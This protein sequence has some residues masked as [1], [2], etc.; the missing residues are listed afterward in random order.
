MRKFSNFLLALLLSPVLLAQHV[1]PI[2]DCSQPGFSVLT[3][4][5]NR[6]PREWTAMPSRVVCQLPSFKMDESF[7]AKNVY[8]SRTDKQVLATGFFRVEKINDRWWIVDPQGYLQINVGVCAINKNSSTRNKAAFAAKYN[9][10]TTDWMRATKDSLKHYG[11]YTS[12]AW[13][14]HDN[15]N[16]DKE[17]NPMPYTPIFNF[18]ATY[19]SRRRSSDYS[20]YGYGNPAY[21]NI[22]N[23]SIHVFDPEFEAFCDHFAKTN[24]RPLELDRDVLGFFSDNELTFS[25]HTLVKYLQVTDKSYPGYLAAKQFV[26][27][28]CFTEADVIANRTTSGATTTLAQLKE[29]W[30]YLLTSTYYGTIRQAIKRYA[31]NHMYIGSRLHIP[32][33]DNAGILKAA[34]DNLDIISFNTYNV[35]HT[36]KQK[37]AFWAT[38]GDTPFLVTEFYAKGEDVFM[39][40]GEKYPN[41]SGVGYIVHTQRERG[42]Y[43]Q[44]FCLGLLEAKNCVGW[45][46]FK[47]MDN[48]PEDPGTSDPSNI[49]SNKGLVDNEYNYYTDMM[50]EAK[51]LNDRVYNL[52]DYFDARTVIPE[53]NGYMEVI[54]PEADANYKNEANEGTSVHLAVKAKD[55][56]RES[57]VRFDLSTLPEPDQI[58]YVGFKL[59]STRTITD[60]QMNVYAID[61]VNDN[62]WTETAILKSNMPA[63][64]MMS[65]H[66]WSTNTG[67]TANVTNFV[68][69]ALL[70]DKK[71]SFKIRA[72]VQGTPDYMSFG[73]RENSDISKRPVL[74]YLLEQDEEDETGIRGNKIDGS[75][76]CFPNPFFR[77]A[78]ISLNAFQA[79]HFRIELFTLN[80]ELIKSLYDGKVAQGQLQIPVS[81][82]NGGMFIVRILQDNNQ[83]AYLKLLSK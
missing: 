74:Q 7:V 35:W 51:V 3:R 12:A 26:E 37:A 71:I 24:C 55:P 64:S 43:Y 34:A 48:D 14:F 50:N 2:P 29:D 46:H 45:H 54:Y 53:D 63:S 76:K 13:T 49:D 11:F 21:S 56:F 66:T 67:T 17:S 77:N 8:G 16:I 39:T 59:E 47:Y 27:S 23:I 28:K 1:V 36:S 9:N 25:D 80:G 5:H 57:I 20:R 58:S 15:L 40:T 79:A 65:I 68:K 42:Y 82:D 61:L 30:Y 70:K 72:D 78:V 62:S 73:S 69:D 52:V 22:S 60:P 41:K 10:S 31:P 18:N 32:S 75:L 6:E 4:R 81:V 83:V 44:T 19:T 38:Y 33:L